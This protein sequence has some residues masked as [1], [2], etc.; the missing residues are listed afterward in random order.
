MKIKKNGSERKGLSAN[1]LVFPLVIVVA[2]LHAT[3]ISLIIAIN[4]ESGSLSSIMQNAGVYTQDASSLLAG[5]S[6]L[7][8]KLTAG[9]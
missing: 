5:S 9:R 8:E 2:L 6:V 3:I 4:T 7:S 1:A